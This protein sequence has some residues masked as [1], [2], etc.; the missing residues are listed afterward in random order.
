MRTIIVETIKM[1]LCLAILF[2]DIFTDF[3]AGISSHIAALMAA[4]RYE[5]CSI[6][7]SRALIV[8]RSCVGWFFTV[9]SWLC[10]GVLCSGT[11]LNTA[12]KE[13]PWVS[14][15]FCLGGRS[16][17]MFLTG[18]CLISLLLG[19]PLQFLSRLLQCFMFSL[20]F[21]LIFLL[22]NWQILQ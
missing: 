19:I 16:F 14:L 3:V 8:R 10:L 4:K 22:C 5:N 15:L 20:L 2:F 9:T 12:E 1:C 18:A 6:L 17:T 21:C 7:R 13:R 11:V